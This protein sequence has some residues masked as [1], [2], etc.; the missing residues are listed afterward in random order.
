MVIIAYF[1]VGDRFLGII[2]DLLCLI[3]LLL[4]LVDLHTSTIL[5]SFALYLDV[6]KGIFFLFMLS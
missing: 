2:F 3:K 4:C 1:L 6:T 5:S